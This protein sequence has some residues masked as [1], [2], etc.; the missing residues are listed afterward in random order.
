[1]NNNRESLTP[2]LK[3]GLDLPE[4]RGGVVYGSMGA[5][6]STVCGVIA[7]RMKR[8]RASFTISGATNLAR[9]LCLK[10]S[11]KLDET[12]ASLSDMKLPATAFEAIAAVLSAAKA[13]KTDGH[14]FGYPVTGGP[15]F[16]NAATTNGRDAVKWLCS[17][18]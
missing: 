16:V 4:A 1:M 15:P 7:L 3:R 6:E 9:L 13:P 18:R 10:R 8:R 5:M 12:M 17:Y 11:G 2:I 14:G